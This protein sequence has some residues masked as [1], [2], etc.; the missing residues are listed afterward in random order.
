MQLPLIFSFWFTVAA[1][2][3][4][5]IDES[6]LGGSFVEKVR[7]HWWPQYSWRQFFWFN[8]G[9]FAVMI[10]SVVIYDFRGGAWAIL[11]LAWAI[12][13][14]CNGFWHVGWAIRFREYS[15]GLV[16]SILMW[17]NFY[18]IVR[19]AS[20][21]EAMG[22]GIWIPAAIIGGLFTAFLVFYIPVVKGRKRSGRPLSV[23]RHEVPR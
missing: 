12:E 7:D 23:P 5:V 9:Y 22:R 20:P 15:P 21:S 17:M 8:A 2:V 14:M 16:S 4:H 10:A 6:L 13:R 3:V 19:Y 18:F 11:P 1:Y